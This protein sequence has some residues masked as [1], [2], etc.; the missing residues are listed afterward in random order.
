MSVKAYLKDHTGVFLICIAGGYAM[1]LFSCRI[2]MESAERYFAAGTF[3]FCIWISMWLGNEGLSHFLDKKIPWTRNPVT[4]LVVGIISV[5]VYTVVTMMILIQAFEWVLDF[6][7]SD[8]FNNVIYPTV[9]ITFLITSFFTSRSFL[10]NWRQQSINAEKLEKEGIK[11][12]Y[13]TL[14]SQV[15]PHFLFNSLNALT[16]LVHDDPD[17]AVKFINKLAQVYRYVLD[18]RDKEIVPL[19]EEVT[20]LKSYI[21]LQQIRFGGKLRIDLSLDSVDSMVAPLCLQM[22]LENCIKHNVVSG[23]SP[24]HI[25]IKS[26]DG[27]IV[28]ENKVVP[29]IDS[30]E[31]S[32]GLGLENIRK[33]YSF[34]CDTPVQVIKADGKFIV[35]L[36]LLNDPIHNPPQLS[37]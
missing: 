2:C 9:V 5:F 25:S 34:L 16:G 36:P 10:V 3:S 29:K 12:Q 14:K 22:L 37:T 17:K 32:P 31:P 26:E 23:D 33:R 11:A 19:S 21:Y 8:S 28:I 20:F 24:L 35:K 4:R 27:H 13:E 15:N 7:F 6:Q 1:P 30:Y 18:T